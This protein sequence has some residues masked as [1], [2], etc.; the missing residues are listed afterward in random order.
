[1]ALGRNRKV[2]DIM[3][4]DISTQSVEAQLGYRQTYDVFISRPADRVAIFR[5]QASPQSTCRPIVRM[6]TSIV[7]DR[8]FVSISAPK[9]QHSP[10]VG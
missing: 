9:Y 6:A 3:A 8:T 2:D 4:S 10:P 7:H 5:K 1:M